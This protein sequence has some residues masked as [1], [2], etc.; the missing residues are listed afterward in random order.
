MED[1]ELAPGGAGEQNESASKPENTEEA[2]A[3]SEGEKPED[4]KAEGQ[5]GE[6]SEEDKAKSEDDGNSDDDDKPKPRKPARERIDELTGKWR[7]AERAVKDMEARAK[8]A[9]ERLKLYEAPP[10]KESDYASYDEFQAALTAFQYRQANKSEKEQD[11]K[12]LN[13]EREAASRESQQALADIYTERASAFAEAVPD[14]YQKTTDPTLPITDEMARQIQASDQGPEVAYYLA[15]NRAEAARLAK[16]S[17]A[18]VAREIGR[19]EGRL[20]QPTPKRVSSAPEPI[21]A[22]VKGSGSQGEWDPR[23]A[24]VDDMEARLKAK[25]VIS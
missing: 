21:T 8:R 11:L 24:S 9:E 2:T 23:K 6:Q 19:I 12:D 18:D 13:A 7:S 4:Q 25:G 17:G 20:T 14:F 22:A 10:P 5:Q 16:L 15:S 1:E 3:K